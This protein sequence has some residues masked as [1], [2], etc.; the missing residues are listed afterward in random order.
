MFQYLGAFSHS[1]QPG[2]RFHL[3]NTWIPYKAALTIFP[4]F[5]SA[6]AVFPAVIHRMDEGIDS[7]V[8]FR[9]CN[10]LS[11]SIGELRKEDC[12]SEVLWIVSCVGS[13]SETTNV[14][15]STPDL[16][17][18]GSADRVVKKIHDKVAY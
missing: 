9:L 11:R 14:R 1:C 4:F 5:S 17:I 18:V 13:G 10:F 15:V 12:G 3:V 6:S 2:V 8:L 7:L 16:R